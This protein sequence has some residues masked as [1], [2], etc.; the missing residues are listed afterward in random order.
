MENPQSQ[1]V[2]AEE[3]KPE[4]IAGYI[5][6]NK[7]QLSTPEDIQAVQDSGDSGN[8]AAE[9]ETVPVG[10]TMAS[11]PTQGKVRLLYKG[12]DGNLWEVEFRNDS[13]QIGDLNSEYVSALYMAIR[14]NTPLKITADGGTTYKINR[15]AG[16]ASERRRGDTIDAQEDTRKDAMKQLGL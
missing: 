13:L 15:L 7:V 10:I 12:T 2:T 14:E 1:E 9:W 3:L 6:K 5:Q 4:N 16:E 11:E 8:F